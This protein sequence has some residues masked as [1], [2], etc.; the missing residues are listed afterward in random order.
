MKVPGLKMAS[1]KRVLGLNHRKH[2]KAFSLLLQSLFAE[3]LEIWF[4]ALCSGPVPNLFKIVVSLGILGLQVIYSEKS[5]SPG[6]AA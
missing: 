4:V 3:I 2:R 6:S 1:P 5:S